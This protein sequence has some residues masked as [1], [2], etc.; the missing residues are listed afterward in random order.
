MIGSA[1]KIHDDAEIKALLMSSGMVKISEAATPK[2]IH[3][4]YWR[5]YANVSD[6]KFSAR[7]ETNQFHFATQFIV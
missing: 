4:L 2:L 5:E 3:A 6:L 7:F 1:E